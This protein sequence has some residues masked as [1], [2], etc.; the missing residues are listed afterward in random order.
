MSCW[1]VT[2]LVDSLGLFQSLQMEYIPQSPKLSLD[3]TMTTLMSHNESRFDPKP[4]LQTKLFSMLKSG[5]SSQRPRSYT[6]HISTM[7]LMQSIL[8]SLVSL[9]I[10]KSDHDRSTHNHP[11]LKHLT[12]NTRTAG[13]S[14][15]QCPWKLKLM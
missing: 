10:T 1:E 11:R 14:T 8:C 4:C 2:S 12:Q 13:S 9:I 3:R 7:A 5:L 15:P 6:K